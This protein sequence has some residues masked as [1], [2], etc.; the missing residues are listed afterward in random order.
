MGEVHIFIFCS[1]HNHH[2]KVNKYTQILRICWQKYY[3]VI[4]SCLFWIAI[5]EFWWA[6]FELHFVLRRVKLF[7]LIGVHCNSCIAYIEQLMWMYRLMKF[8]NNWIIIVVILYLLICCMTFYPP[9]YM[10]MDNYMY[11]HVL[12]HCTFECLQKKSTG[13]SCGTRPNPPPPAYY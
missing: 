3:C 10:Y 11:L 8:L 5:L 2:C 9:T 12:Q 6:I 4:I 7:T 1:G 13:Y